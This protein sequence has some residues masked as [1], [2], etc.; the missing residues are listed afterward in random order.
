MFRPNNSRYIHV[1][2]LLN[3]EY[4]HFTFGTL[5]LFQLLIKY[6]IHLYFNAFISEVFHVLFLILFTKNISINVTPAD[7]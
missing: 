4:T 1:I 7:F 5:S 2:F 3:F 6:L